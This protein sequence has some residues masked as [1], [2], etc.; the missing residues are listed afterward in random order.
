M[1]KLI[2]SVFVGLM[3]VCGVVG[4]NAQTVQIPTLTSQSYA[5]LKKD[6]VYVV[7]FSAS[8]CRPCLIAKK[9]VMPE[10]AEQYAQDEKVHVYIFRTDEDVAAA[11][12][13]HLDE[14]LGVDRVPTFAVLYNG[15]VMWRQMGFSASQAENL[16]QQIA[17]EV[18]RLK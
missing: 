15:T 18:A 8:Y 16:K 17:A 9:T 1:K 5:S 7:L 12:G 13:T 10:L 6:E 4:L 14:T 11:D 3:V 2:L